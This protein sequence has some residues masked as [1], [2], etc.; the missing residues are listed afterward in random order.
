[1]RRTGLVHQLPP[2]RLA[3]GRLENLRVGS[4]VISQGWWARA[5]RGTI[6]SRRTLGAAVAIAA[7]AALAVC[8][9]PEAA[10]AATSASASS[11]SAPVAGPY[12]AVTPYR[13]CDTRPAGQGIAANQCND[14]S[15]GAGKGPISQG[16]TR[17]ITVDGFGNVP[18]SGVTAVVVNL[19]AVD[20]TKGT[21]LT[22]FEDGLAHRPG[23]ANLNPAPG[24][25]LANL[26]E[27]GV[28]AAGK[29]DVFN[30]LGTTNVVI[31]IEGYVAPAS[32]SG[33]YTSTAPLRICDTR[34]PGHGIATNRC[35]MGTPRPIGAGATLTFAVSG[36]GSPVPGTGVAAVA[37]NLSAITPTVPTVL[38]AF[39]GGGVRPNAS[40]LNVQ[41]HAVL[42]NRVIVPVTCAGGSCSVS[43][44][45]S[46]G[47][48]NIAVD[49]NGW[50]STG[51][52]AE[53]TA[54]TTPARI[55]DTVLGTATCARA[56]IGSGQVLNTP[57]AG[58]DGIPP[59]TGGAGSP[60][61]IVANV[62]AVNATK[63]TY[64]TV[65]PGPLSQSP[66]GASDLN[67]AAGVTSANLVVV[68]VGSD[69]T[70]NLF[71]D[72]GT[73]NLIVDVLGYYSS[74]SAAPL[75][76]P[77]Y[78][79]TLVGPGQ[80][81]MYPVDV[82]N[83]A[84]YYFVLDAG[85]YRIIAV[86][87]TTDAIDCQI[88]G[89]QGNGPGQ[90]GDARA[91]DYDSSNNELFVADTPNNRIEVFSFS[92]SACATDSP[93]AFTFLSQFGTR[94]S[95]DE[96]FS[97]V[98]GVAVDAAHS[99]VYA[100]DGA[101]R[102]EK[103]D[104]A[105]N[106]ISQFNAGGTLN[107]PRQVTVA[108]N[109]DVLVMDARNH[110]CDVFDD[111]GTLLFSFGS[112]GTGPGQFTDD[113]RGVAVSADGTLAFV[114]DSGGKRVEVFNLQASGG[115]YTGATFAYTI[116]SAASGAGQFVGPRGLTTTS[117]NHLLLTDEWG[118]NLHEMT[119][120]AT[121]ATSTVNTTPSA[122][123]V[124]GVNAPRGV[125]VAA[126]GQIYIVDY[127]NQRVEYMNAN[128]SGAGSFGFRGNPSQSGAINFAWDAAIQ[129]GTGDIFVANREND[130]VAVFSPT[131]AS[132]LIF[133]KN[134]AANGQFSFPQGIAFAPD[135]TLLV[136][137]SGNDRIERFSLAP[138][139]ASA[140]WVAT[141]GQTGIGSTAPAGDL[142]NPTGISVA[143]DG[144]I[145]V[146]D[147]L[148]N[149]IQS[150]SP[151]GVWTAITKPIGPGPQPPFNIPWGVTVAP[152]GSIWV[153]DTGN[154]RVVSV[155][156]SGNL[157][158]SANAASM[159]IPAAPDDSVVY[160]FAL[161][162]SGDTVYLSDIWNNRVLV[163]TTH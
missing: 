57:V 121:A 139:D 80:A 103:S 100:V 94:G 163:L 88:G 8:G 77:V 127:W 154:N 91:L 48:V 9:A 72:V 105:G 89:L 106:L 158:F 58:V 107:E 73:V 45:N 27:V 98:Y 34:A 143:P 101:G 19:T 65:Y 11:P 49:I 14:N 159:G 7:V 43:I 1:M 4:G 29:I 125:H 152:D 160:P 150:M 97:Q 46:V 5:R 136:D 67:V 17:V 12:T 41:A 53:F 104:L 133:G 75:G 38:T 40:N 82:S 13:V 120:T 129:P 140:T 119:F 109:S 111:S 130:Q 114:T 93:S 112:L 110:Q 24:A 132:L 131:G 124:P 37:F 99:W 66:P 39:A 21:Y 118:F 32:S 63:G 117:D 81:D 157:I 153:S 76:S 71:N 59:D 2:P 68:G 51:S 113:P 84:Q 134:G 33:L 78:S 108:P 3:R 135:G 20:P 44:W 74:G 155:D 6:I 148:N 36:M 23:T 126:S 60:T 123:P 96:Q 35:N 30:A 87:R 61:A 31:D 144:T 25:V 10:S 128:G 116:P 16:A 15:T 92:A 138:G 147:T 56:P 162:F 85:N 141:Y 146:A 122:A 42:P 142:N 28:S 95:G 26:V 64:V 54:L 50:F 137:D 22:V 90:I 70:I 151:G 79:S 156:T 86:N 83:D 115:D 102:V 18:A 55:C 52:G 47:A 69:G 161:A 62:T 149:R 145:W